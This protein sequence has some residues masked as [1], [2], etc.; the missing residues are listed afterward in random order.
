MKIHRASSNQSNK[1]YGRR[2][3][4][5]CMS[6]CFMFLHTMFLRN[7]KKYTTEFLDDVLNNG[8]T[9][10][11]EVE[12]SLLTQQP[13]RPLHPYR[14]S[15]EV[16]RIIKSPIGTTAHVLS[17]AFSGTMETIDL[18]GYKCFGIFDFLVYASRKQKPCYIIITVGSLTRAM[19][20]TKGPTI[21]FDPHASTLADEAAVYECEAMDDVLSIMTGF[22]ATGDSF[23]YDASVVYLIDVNS[24]PDTTENGIYHA[25]MALYKDPDMAFPILKDRHPPATLADAPQ[26][27][28]EPIEVDEAKRFAGKKRSAA[29]EK[30]SQKP[31][32]I[33]RSHTSCLT[34]AALLPALSNFEAVINTFDKESRKYRSNAEA[35]AGW[36]IR[37]VS[38]KPFDEDFLTERICH[39][40]AHNI[41]A[42]SSMRLG[43]I[44]DTDTQTPLQPTTANAKQR[45]MFMIRH[46]QAFLG[47]SPQIDAFINTL[48][49]YDLNLILLYNN[50]ATSLQQ[51]SYLDKLLFSKMVSVFERWADEHAEPIKQWIKTLIDTVDKA[52]VKL[53]VATIKDFCDKNHLPISQPFVCLRQSDRDFISDI[54]KLKVRD[55]ASKYLETQRTYKEVLRIISDTTVDDAPTRDAASKPSLADNGGKHKNGRAPRRI[56]DAGPGTVDIPDITDLDDD[57]T[58]VL[59]DVTSAKM[60]DMYEELRAEFSEMIRDSHNKIVNGYMPSADFDTFTKRVHSAIDKGTVFRHADL[61]A[62]DTIKDLQ[63][64][65]DNALFISQGR[66]TFSE[67]N[68]DASI[69]NL[70][71]EYSK[72]VAEQETAKT[73]IAEILSGME[74]L[75]NDEKSINEASLDM[76]TAQ[77]AQLQSM[78]LSVV[79]DADKR[80]ATIVRKLG[81]LTAQKQRT[82]QFVDKMSYDAVT[83]ASALKNYGM[84][85][86]MLRDDVHLA[87][88]YAN[89]IVQ[90]LNELVSRLESYEAPKDEW[91][92]ALDLILD[93]LPEGTDLAIL[94]SAKD[95]LAKLTRRIRALQASKKEDHRRLLIEAVRFFLDNDRALHDLIRLGCGPRLPAIYE[96]L[97]SRLEQDV[98]AESER[99]WKETA[100]KTDIRDEEAL[101]RLLQTAPSE[102]IAL[103]VIPELRAKLHK[104]TQADEIKRKE[105]ADKKKNELK[106]R[107]VSDLN[108][109]PAALKSNT[110]SA[111][112]TIDFAAVEGMASALAED[113]SALVEKFNVDLMGALKDLETKIKTTENDLLS[114]VIQDTDPTSVSNTPLRCE[115][116]EA[117]HRSAHTLSRYQSLL[118][119]EASEGLSRTMTELEFIQ[120][121]VTRWRDKDSLFRDTPYGA[122]YED[123]KR[124]LAA[125]DAGLQRARDDATEQANA[126]DAE[127]ASRG[128]HVTDKHT[129]SPSPILSNEERAQ[130]EAIKPPFFKDR[131]HNQLVAAESSL[132]DDTAILT[133]KIKSQ[134]ELHNKKIDSKQ[135]RWKDLI[136]RH[137]TRSAEGINIDYKKL[138]DD[139]VGTISAMIAAAV[140]T[141]P[142]ITAHRTLQWAALFTTEALNETQG[143]GTSQ[144]DETA[145]RTN[146]AS[147]STKIEHE[148]QE[149]DE[150]IK[151]NA[152]CENAALEL[153]NA[154]TDSPKAVQLADTIEIGLSHLQPKRISGGEERYRFLLQR[155]Q[156][157]KHLMQQLEEYEKLCM[158]YFELL[159]NIKNWQYGLDFA[160]Q[161]EKIAELKT[162]FTTFAKTALPT[163]ETETFPSPVRNTVQNEHP[164]RFLRGLAALDT[165]VL[166]YQTHLMNLVSEQFTVAGSVADVAT[167]EPP[168][169]STIT[170]IQDNTTRLRASEK[171]DTFY[172]VID[173]FGDQ[174]IISR[175][176]VPIDVQLG[177]GNAIF[178]KFL[179]HPPNRQDHPLPQTTVTS[180]YKTTMVTAT[181]ASSIQSFWNQ[182]STVNL[183]PILNEE[184]GYLRTLNREAYIL[185]NL[186]LFAYILSTVWSADERDDESTHLSITLTDLCTLVSCVHPEFAYGIIQNPVS[187]S[188]ASLLTALDKESLFSVLTVSTNPPKTIT[189][190]SYCIDPTQWKKA[191]VDRTM[192]NSELVRQLCS[193]GPCKTA[194]P[195][196][197]LYSLATVTLPINVLQCLWIQY[198]PRYADHMTS[199]F[200]FVATLYEELYDRNDI[201]RRPPTALDVKSVSPGHRILQ[202]VITRQKQRNDRD[203]QTMTA[204][205]ASTNAV[206]DYIL[207]SYVF[208]VPITV[209][210]HAADIMNGARRILIRCMENTYTDIDYV[211]V[212]RS[213]ELDVSHIL[214]NTWTDNLLEQSW[215]RAQLHRLHDTMFSRAHQDETVPLI[216]YTPT[217]NTVT[218]VL[219]PPDSAT[220]T[221]QKVLRFSFQNTFSPPT[222]KTDPTPDT[223]IF[224]RFPTDVDFLND[225]PPNMYPQAPDSPAGDH[226]LHQTHMTP[227]IT[228]IPSPHPQTPHPGASISLK[229]FDEPLFD[230][231]HIVD[232]TP[233]DEITTI[234]PSAATPDFSYNPLEFV[235]EGVR[236]AI[237]IL[238]ELRK[239]ITNLEDEVHETLR[240][241]RVMYLN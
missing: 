21:I 153:D 36:T 140:D 241:F 114:A 119:Y 43:L 64:L 29:D 91:L 222:F 88:R 236:A 37:S 134:V 97:K 73:Q 20:F 215:H 52:P 221:T 68:I 121:I 86:S 59:R 15:T 229:S 163:S 26:T 193:R 230:Q 182:I 42:L 32:V 224:S 12:L 225:P 9:L 217:D 30:P 219:Q 228:V 186:K 173:V 7:P 53:T 8:I 106:K 61:C 176:L 214:T 196:L 1:K 239:H 237:N 223:S 18:D 72:A 167:V 161:L 197:L 136:N 19:I 138:S 204:A 100:L 11:S 74:L 220:T 2:A 14:L 107:L 207:G 164:S 87:Q 146:L 158:A 188:F 150:K 35:R 69:L 116:V 227:E 113:A 10:D 104:V 170:T 95:L 101:T 192:W 120:S 80:L 144:E 235:A 156:A 209:C 66:I 151:F 234:S 96:N 141:L 125:I 105:D 148:S 240:R 62:T 94:R 67:K 232:I 51:P 185:I 39:L 46:V 198:R 160:T 57:S 3:G 238:R 210:I 165:L 166:H 41:D 216:T 133:S 233:K 218:A 78:N 25:L 71:T 23:Y 191:T 22:G 44:D 168:H 169:R 139:P 157:V 190:P 208:D 126:I 70:K 152:A 28:D 24:L 103:D 187:T 132:K 194:G 199:I 102:R 111:I 180:R 184:I 201:D 143:P 60:K 178:K 117:L 183:G 211:N 177:Y 55:L 206:L 212:L 123:F 48:Q 142:Y 115:T 130:M 81:D 17:K 108:R 129:L 147:L 195:K 34:Q 49:K 93:Q 40:I 127:I 231:K 202:T 58:R 137:K 90:I 84:L 213:R 16:P 99:A 77:I 85:K 75:L 171:T 174:T 33:K 200:D 83:G 189:T 112:N 145:F 226:D 109:I 98:L 31:K 122:A 89:N 82:V 38:G 27:E 45:R 13:T 5:Q 65:H 56:G 4:S 92:H 131:L 63:R 149:I 54:I 128:G 79:K 172:E 135:T 118:T 47:V 50:Y 203:G 159:Y 179:L 110:P 76:M 175:S 162:G 6:N 124:I 155:A 154:D 181:I 205:L